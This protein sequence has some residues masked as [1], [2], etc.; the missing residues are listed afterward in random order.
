M[1]KTEVLSQ[2]N[3]LTSKLIAVSLSEEQ[4]FPSEKDGSIYISGSHDLSIAL[5]NISYEEIYSVLDRDK[6]YNIKMIDGALIQIMYSFDEDSGDLKKYRLAFFPSPSLEEFQ[7]N[8]D[9]YELDEIYADIISKSI[10]SSPIRFDYDPTNFKILEHPRSHLTIGQYKNCRI[11]V[12]APLTPNIFI[13]FILRNFY[14]T[15][16]K[17][18][19]DELNFDKKP[20]FNNCIHGDEQSILHLTIVV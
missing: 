9:L 8:S 12:S 20:C 3:Q 14:N 1:T 19:S 7:N 15:A 4:N 2:I 10:V 13:D 6:N 5:R 18:F 17:K 16:K 11:P